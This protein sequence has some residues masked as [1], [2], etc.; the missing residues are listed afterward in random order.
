MV[1]TISAR[2]RSMM[3]AMQEI[4]IPAVDPQHAIAQEQ[5]KL[6]LG[7]LNLI[8]QQLDYAHAFEVVEAREMQSLGRELADL[9]D[10]VKP[11]HAT[12]R[13]ARA[14]LAAHAAIENPVTTLST[15]QQINQALR[16]TIA[17]LIQLSEDSTDLSLITKVSRRVIDY[18]ESQLVR[19]RSWV[20]ATGFDPPGAT[21]PLA[22]AIQIITAPEAT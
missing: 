16:A 7:S 13:R 2:L 6:V 15:L 14:D 21:V 22:D 1:P 4:V 9:I 12:T 17:E 3:K 20:A 5:S 8:L 11:S 18:S 19:E 10:D